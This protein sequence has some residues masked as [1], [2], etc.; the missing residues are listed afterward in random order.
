MLIRVSPR[1]A[2][3]WGSPL[4]GL[5]NRKIARRRREMKV[6]A[7]KTG[8][9]VLGWCIGDSWRKPRAAHHVKEDHSWLLAGAL[10]RTASEG[11]PYDSSRAIM[12]C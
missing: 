11:R 5:Q 7:R 8:C 3:L 10:E 1:A 9:A 6:R 12:A 4:D 2:I